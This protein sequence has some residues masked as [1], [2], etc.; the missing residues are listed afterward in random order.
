M[1]YAKLTSAIAA[2][3]IA[4]LA[5]A[6]GAQT[7]GYLNLPGVLPHMAFIDFDAFHLAGRM[8]LQGNMGV[9]YDPVRMF[10]AEE[11]AGAAGLRMP[12]AYPPQFDLIVAALAL[13]PVGLAYALFTAAGLAA[14]LAV[15]RALAGARFAETVIFTAP[16]L[17]LTVYSGQNGLLTGTLTG[18]FALAV[19]RGRAVAGVP[20]G[21]MIIKPHLALGLGVLV[22]A[23]ARWRVL[24]VAILTA[25]LTGGLG[26]LAFGP[27][28][29]MDFARGLQITG[30]LLQRGAFQFFRLISVYGTVRA[31]GFGAGPA[32]AAQGV[33]AL[34]A[35]A[36]IVAMAPSHLGPRV[37]LGIA[38]LGTLAISPYAYDYD[39]P[40]IGVAVALLL[41]DLAVRLRPVEAVGLLALTWVAT[42]WSV[43][44]ILRFQSGARAE[45]MVG[46][47]QALA[48]AGAAYV[49]LIAVVALI[50]W[51]RVPRA[52]E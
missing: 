25:V 6:I 10:A 30:D 48:A 23:Q 37:A 28:I 17:I 38:A 5:M 40:I 18:L 47:G 8:G 20:L 3:L 31:L 32:L 52:P 22:L 14:Y 42:G 13:L 21:L 1:T 39:L 44:L 36:L 41:P 7:A 45:A 4:L 19:L 12:W 34:A 49:A 15:L 9:A 16:A 2:A 43:W 24:A 35:V 26:A 50:L 46:T 11:A 27:G 33:V 51:R 29:W